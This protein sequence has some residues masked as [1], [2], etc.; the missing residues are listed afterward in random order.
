[1]NGLRTA[2]EELAGLFVDDG[3]LASFAVV[4]ILVVA[5]AVKLANLPP[6]WGALLLF[7]GVIGILAESLVR[8]VRTEKK[9]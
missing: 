2:W 4:L 6:L 5:G 7:V 8:A 1:M 3:S 9:R